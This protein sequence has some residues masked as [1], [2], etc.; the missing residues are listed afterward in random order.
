M[1]PRAAM[2]KKR[3]IQNDVDHG[4]GD[5]DNCRSPDSLDQYSQVDDYH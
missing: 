4:E 3:K 1:M 2:V 5:K